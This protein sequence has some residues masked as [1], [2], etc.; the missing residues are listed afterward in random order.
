MADNQ[1]VESLPSIGTATIGRGGV[2]QDRAVLR[3]DT[4]DTLLMRVA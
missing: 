4:F 1:D 3:V 2:P